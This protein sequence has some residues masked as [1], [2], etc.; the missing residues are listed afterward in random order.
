MVSVSEQNRLDHLEGA[1]WSFRSVPVW[2]EVLDHSGT[3]RTLVLEELWFWT[4]EGEVGN[5]RGFCSKLRVKGSQHGSSSSCFP[6]GPLPDAVF[7][8]GAPPFSRRAR[9]RSQQS[10]LDLFLPNW[11]PPRQKKVTGTA[12]EGKRGTLSSYSVKAWRTT[13]PPSGASSD[14]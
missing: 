1:E 4:T 10:C 8:T 14:R 12:A 13:A 3:G 5:K 11:D 6:F 2:M 9:P 7:R